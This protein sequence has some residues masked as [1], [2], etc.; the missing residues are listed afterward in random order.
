ML[1]RTVKARVSNVEE[2]SR[3]RPHWP[4]L[5]CSRKECLSCAAGRKFFRV[6]KEC[7][8]YLSAIVC[9]S[10]IP[11]LNSTGNTRRGLPSLISSGKVWKTTRGNGTSTVKWSLNAERKKKKRNGRSND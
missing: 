2:T 5:T 6:N 7:L 10:L 8:Q 1:S 4:W 9:C 11:T 3:S